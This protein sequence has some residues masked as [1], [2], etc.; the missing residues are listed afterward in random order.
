ML[1]SALI[2]SAVVEAAGFSV[3]REY[4]GH[5][6]GR[7][8]HLDPHVSHVGRAGSG[9]RLREGMAFTVE[10]M[11]NAGAAEI[12]TDADGWTVRTAD[13]SLSAQFEH[14]I[15]VTKSGCEVLTHRERAL[16]CSENVATLFVA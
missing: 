6:I 8:M 15:V 3:V 14:T 9:H 13:G 16:R 1:P 10:P 4:G 11:V 12:R 7:A 2:L 5:G